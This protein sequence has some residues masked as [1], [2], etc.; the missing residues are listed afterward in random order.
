MD[1]DEVEFRRRYGDWRRVTPRDAAAL[2]QDI[3]I[4]WWVAGG[5]A[6]EAYTGVARRHEDIDVAFFRTDLAAVRAHFAATHHLWAAGDGALRPVTDERP[7]L[8]DWAEQMWVREHAHAPWLLDLLA[9]PGDVGGWIFK[10]DVT[11]VRPLAEVTWVGADGV[12]YLSP[13]VVLA[14]KAKLDRPKDHAD[15]DA[16]LPRL[17]GAA[18]DWLAATV[19]R[20]HPGHAWLPLLRA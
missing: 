20:L 18:R 1:D 9:N 3:G 16:V 10:R 2:L 7:E 5:W 13:E 17:D 14:Y 12:R 19:E 11:V 6:L 8:P 4:P 15:L